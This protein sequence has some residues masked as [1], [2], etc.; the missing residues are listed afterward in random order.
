VLLSPKS[1]VPS[2]LYAPVMEMGAVGVATTAAAVGV[3]TTVVGATTGGVTGAVAAG[4]VAAG[5]GVGM[6]PPALLFIRFQNELPSSGSGS[7]T[8]VRKSASH[9][10]EYGEHPWANTRGGCRQHALTVDGVVRWSSA[11]SR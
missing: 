1:Y 5:A 4:A 11:A 7:V 9:S 6:G 3:A 10:H 2:G 8:S